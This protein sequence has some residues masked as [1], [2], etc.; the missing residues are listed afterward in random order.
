MFL[1]VGAFILVN[2]V[3]SPQFVLWI[4]PLLVLALPNWRDFLIFSA[5]ELLHFWAIWAYLAGPI[6]EYDVQHQLDEK[7]YLLAVAGHVV[8]LIYL[9]LRVVMDMYEPNQDRV[10]N[11]LRHADSQLLPDDDPSGAEFDGAPDRF[12]LRK[13]ANV[14][15][16]EL[17][18]LKPM[19]QCLDDSHSSRYRALPSPRR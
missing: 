19:T 6:S 10:R 5:V 3:Y 9:M 4:I 16:H 11:S 18:P 12:V 14:R 17:R 13:P 8:V 1:I 2:K 7:L 15:C